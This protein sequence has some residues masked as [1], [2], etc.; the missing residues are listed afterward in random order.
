MRFFLI[1]LAAVAGFTL[2]FYL[3]PAQMFQVALSNGS[4]EIFVD[5]SL[6]TLLYKTDFPEGILAE[7]VKT[8]SLTY[9]GIMLLIICLAGIPLMIAYRFTKTK[10]AQQ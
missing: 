1:F 4:A 2:F 8:M 6:K 10:Q 7:N 3:Y 9:Q 5:V